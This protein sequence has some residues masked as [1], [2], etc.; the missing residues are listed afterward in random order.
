MLA[1]Y[2]PGARSDRVRPGRMTTVLT[3]LGSVELLPE[4]A[5]GG[6]GDGALAA[7]GSV[8][9]GATGAGSTTLGAAWVPSSLTATGSS[10]FETT[11]SLAACATSS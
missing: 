8:C 6:A 11:C 7:G 10:C 9:I 2:R 3:F 5:A 1:G 4:G